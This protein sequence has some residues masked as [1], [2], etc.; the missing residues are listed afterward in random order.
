MPV[1]AIYSEA[2]RAQYSGERYLHY[3]SLDEL[4]QRYLDLLTN[5]LGF[6]E[7]GKPQFI[8]LDRDTAW[9]RRIADVVA[10]IDL[11]S[12]PRGWLDSVEQKALNRPYPRVL[13]ALEAWGSQNPAPGSHLIKYGHR[14]H[15]AALVERG[16][17]RLTPASCYG[18]P[19]LNP[20]IRD[21][22]LE[23]AFHLP[24][25]TRIERKSDSGVYE[26][27]RGLC[28]LITPTR[29]SEDYYVFCASDAFDARAFDEFGYDACVLISDWRRFIDA[30]KSCPAPAR[31]ISAGPTVYVDPFRPHRQATVPLTKHLRY[32]YQRVAD[33]LGK[34]APAAA[35][36]VLP[37]SR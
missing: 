24:P 7:A 25:G 12:E 9:T 37:D 18:D 20:A 3:L 34:A 17:V 6:T 29:R 15:M 14:A 30:I 11:R 13:R 22:E 32:A 10:E 8:G 2:W 4:G 27:I 26:E 19:S 23:F 35:Q 21:S 1:P 16:Q 5:V 31:E 28:S 36:A 33:R